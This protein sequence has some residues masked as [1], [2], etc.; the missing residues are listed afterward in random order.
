MI[1]IIISSIKRITININT[2][3]SSATTKSKTSIRVLE[4][5]IDDKLR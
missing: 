2:K 5:Q 4:L 1:I 3:F